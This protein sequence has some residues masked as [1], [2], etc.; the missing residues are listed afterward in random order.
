V[1][2]ALEYT[3]PETK[4]LRSDRID[5]IYPLLLSPFQLYNNCHGSDPIGTKKKAA[6]QL[7]VLSW[8][9]YQTFGMNVD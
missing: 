7:V 1:G 8:G 9:E 3:T 4:D 6:E 2:A 5:N